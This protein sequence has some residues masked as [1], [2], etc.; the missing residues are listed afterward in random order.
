MIAEPLRPHTW[1][2]QPQAPRATL[3]MY[4][5]TVGCALCLSEA[6]E[7]GI[8][9][10]RALLLYLGAVFKLRT[11]ARATSSV[12]VLSHND[13][14]N[15]IIKIPRYFTRDFTNG[16]PSRPTNS[17]ISCDNS[18][19]KVPYLGLS[20]SLCRIT[21]TWISPSDRILLP[22]TKMSSSCTTI[23]RP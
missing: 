1:P 6:S 15:S 16:Q 21:T 12:L 11:V 4:Q 2:L 14:D 9:N 7:L 23:I 5:V 18:N 8:L 13:T 17:F 19:T 22:R 3:R 10:S 20:S